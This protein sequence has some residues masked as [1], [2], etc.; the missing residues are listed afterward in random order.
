M[1]I[2][3]LKLSNVKKIA[4]LRANAL[5]DFIVILP[6]LQALRATYPEAEIVLLGKPW[7]QKFLSKGRTPVDRVIVVP[8][9]KGI[10]EEATMKEDLRTQDLFFKQMHAEKF[11]VAISFQGIGIAANPFIKRLGATLTVGT[12]CRE[13]ERIDRSIEYYH[14]QHEV[15]RYL[16][17]VKLIGA[18]TDAIEPRLNVLAEDKKEI[19]DFDLQLENKPYV[20]LNP[21]ANDI[22]RMWPLENYAWLANV[23]LK[24]N[25]AVIITGST[26]DRTLADTIISSMEY[27]GTN[28]CGISIGGLAA[29]ASKALLMVSPDTGPLHVAQAVCCPTVGI[30]WGPNLIN[31]GP[32]NRQFHK[33]VISWKMECPYCGVVPNDPYP[34]EPTT[35]C[36]HEVSFVRDITP[37]KVLHAAADLLH[38]KTRRI[39]DQHQ[40]N[41]C[42]TNVKIPTL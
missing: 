19:R 28:A 41:S 26:E 5:G 35:T 23:F 24:K 37:E 40:K 42:I 32:L 33:P 10:R 20:I 3:H 27:P 12:S 18:T 17:I 7:H 9:K 29:L 25:I 6:A 38:I 2:D 30:Y 4:V 22:R 14:Y 21:F 39:N 16:E 36:S 31:W 13:A 1:N 34:F 8:I 11:D 15:M